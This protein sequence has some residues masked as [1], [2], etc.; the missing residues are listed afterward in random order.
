MVADR[1]QPQGPTLKRCTA[2]LPR[3]PAAPLKEGSTQRA[4]P[5][6]AAQGL[7][8]SSAVPVRSTRPDSDW[9]T[10]PTPDLIQMQA[11]PASESVFAEFDCHGGWHAPPQA[12]TIAL[13]YSA[14]LLRVR[15]RDHLK[16]SVQGSERR[17]TV[18]G[19]SAM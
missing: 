4:S 18:F 2:L 9:M 16:P 13:Q 12:Q 5:S 10:P 7:I 15:L 3:L 11:L 6:T 1:E 19:A 8:D 17:R 14:T